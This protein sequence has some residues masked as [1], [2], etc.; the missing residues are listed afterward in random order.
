MRVTCFGLKELSS[1]HGRSGALSRIRP[2]LLIGV[3]ALTAG[4]GVGALAPS[5]N[6]DG[7]FPCGGQR[8]RDGEDLASAINGAQ[9][10]TT[11]CIEGGDYPISETIE[12][13]DGDVI[14]GE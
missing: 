4:F 5:K 11:F 2:F 3:F 9:A 12:V 13:Q 1:D 6:G 14:N 7:G 8:G 10:G